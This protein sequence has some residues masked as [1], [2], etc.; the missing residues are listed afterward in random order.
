M[1]RSK[2]VG[3]WIRVS[4]EDQVRGESPA[5]HEERARAYA[6]A[7]GWDVGAVYRLDAVSG[8]SVME[9]PACRAM[10]DDIAEK[11]IT[12]LIFSKLARLARNTKEL[13]DFADYFETHGA[14]LVS[15]QEAIDT[16]TPAGRLF[17]TM[18]AA[19]AQWEREEIASRV[20]ASVPIRAKLG[21]PLGGAAPYGYRWQDK[22][23]VVDPE[24]APVRKL[25][26]ELFFTH[27]RLKTVARILNEKGHR[28]RKGSQWSD[29]TIRRLLED[30]TAKGLH[31]A[32]Y[33]RSPGRRK[34]LGPQARGGLDPPAGR[35]GGLCGGLGSVPR[36]PGR[37]PCGAQAPGQTASEPVRKP[38]LLRLRREDDRALEPTFRG[39][40]IHFVR[41]YPDEL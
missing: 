19:L 18:I 40:E 22:Q 14:D 35:A 34:G 26:H 8:K 33:T 24:E 31:R 17:Y 29:T 4:H 39:S 41:N 11:R 13:L 3:I 20:A 6:R 2:S 7:K 15:L 32:N 5:H 23:L 21:K 36:D 10:L 38:R 27:R 1:S 9:L 12:G 30:P 16:S 37:A 28:T 25:L